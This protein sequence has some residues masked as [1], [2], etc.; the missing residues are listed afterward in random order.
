[1]NSL[2]PKGIY[3][4][5]ANLFGSDEEVVQ[6]SCTEKQEKQEEARNVTCQLF[7]SSALLAVPH[8]ISSSVSDAEAGAHLPTPNSSEIQ[9]LTVA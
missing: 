8:P 6:T 5:C 4:E 7:L 9:I 2:F 3:S 1:M